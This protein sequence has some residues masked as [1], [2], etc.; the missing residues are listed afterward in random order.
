MSAIPRKPGGKPEDSNTKAVPLKDFP[1]FIKNKGSESLLG[2]QEAEETPQKPEDYLALDL[3]GLEGKQSERIAR[4]LAAIRDTDTRGNGISD[5]KN[6]KNKTLADQEAQLSKDDAEILRIIREAKDGIKTIKGTDGAWSMEK[7]DWTKSY[8]LPADKKSL[9]LDGVLSSISIW[10]DQIQAVKDAVSNIKDKKES[11]KI[12]SNTVLEEVTRSKKNAG[13]LPSSIMVREFKK[14]FGKEVYDYLNSNTN[15]KIAAE[16]AEE[17][18]KR[19][20]TD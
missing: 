5:L 1:A 12:A 19:I 2:P 13:G 3:R 16:I 8:K 6:S 9:I 10:V 7:I 20:D 18:L 14:M 15:E 4:E 11:L 17:I